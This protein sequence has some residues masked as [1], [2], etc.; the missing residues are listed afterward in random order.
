MLLTL[1]L[2][3]LL[4]PGSWL[5]YHKSRLWRQQRYLRRHGQAAVATVATVARVV[6]APEG[7]VLPLRFETPAGGW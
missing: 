3:L 7:D 1:S 4:L 5:L 6:A 2:N